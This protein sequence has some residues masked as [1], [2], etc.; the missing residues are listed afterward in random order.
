MYVWQERRGRKDKAVCFHLKLVQPFD[1]WYTP[2]LMSL[3]I[4]AVTSQISFTLWTMRF[5]VFLLIL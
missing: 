1:Y 2:P 3:Q 4:K 5:G